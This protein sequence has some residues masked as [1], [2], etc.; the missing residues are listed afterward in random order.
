MA[1]ETARQALREPPP[2]EPLPRAAEVV[3]I[4]GGVI[5]ASIAFHLAEAGIRDVLV[6]ERDT[7]ASGSS[8]KP[9]GG[10]RA[11]FSD[12]LNIRLGQRSLRAWR[13]FGVRPGADVGLDRVGYLFLLRR[14][15]DVAAFR[16]AAAVQRELGV[17]CRIVEPREAHRLCPYVDPGAIVAAAHSP[18]DGFA[19]PGPAVRGYLRAARG[20]GVTVRT[21]CAVTGFERDGDALTAVRTSAG[22]VRT[23]A[24][25]CA[26]GAWSGGV[27]AL[28]GH[29]LPVTPLRRQIALTG[30]VAPTPPRIPFT[31][32]FAST[33]YFHGDNAGGLV[34]GLS[35]PRQE[36]G[37]GREFTDEWL[38]PFR[39][40]AARVAPSLAELEPAGGGWAGLYEMTPDR[41]ALIGEATGPGRF[42]YA[43][44]FSGHGFLQAP[45]VGEIVRDLYLGRE[46]FLDVGPLAATRFGT[47]GNRAAVRPE[48][49]II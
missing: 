3:V 45:A 39:A 21:H 18:D 15:E 5:G 9:I 4:G 33:L 13:E 14:E 41:N 22:T 37:F 11:Q 36:P 28:A 48:A 44:G 6:V 2:P 46:P 35:D 26:A 10:V 38:D 29:S 7:L 1:H 24:V 34:L 27:A 19:L 20:L 42:L 40:A 23:G 47:E 25:V 17:D 43:T 49:H 16:E 31:L 12:P 8:G 32:D 30:P